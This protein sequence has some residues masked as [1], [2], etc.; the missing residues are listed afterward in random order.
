MTAARHS[1]FISYRRADSVYAVDQLDERLKQAFDAE[2][3]FRDASSIV[4]GAVFPQTIRDALA[5]AR[6]ALVVIGPAW[7]RATAN[8]NDPH[9]PRRIDDPAD[10]VR[11]EIETLLSRGDGVTVIPVL[12]GGACVPWPDDLPTALQALPTRNGMTLPP[13][14]NFADSLRQ[15]VDA[16]AGLLKVTPQ[17]VAADRAPAAEQPPRFG[18]NDFSVTGSKFVGRE[19]ELHML[20][21]A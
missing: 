20:D 19:R 2:A 11:L 16:V 14:P 21:E 13:F 9:G 17:S 7:L 18:G 6:V 5:V 3:V 15:L 10:W 12:L 4:P 1:I 8:L